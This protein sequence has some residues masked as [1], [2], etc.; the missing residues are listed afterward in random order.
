MG[1]GI[2]TLTAKKVKSPKESPI[3]D[4]IFRRVYNP[5]FD[6]FETIFKNSSKFRLLIRLSL[7]ISRDEPSLSKYNKSIPLMLYIVFSL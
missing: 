4:H 7:L 6:G 2:T 5:S 3:Y 1:L